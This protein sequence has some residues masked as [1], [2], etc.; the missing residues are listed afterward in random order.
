M[1]II[2][3]QCAPGASLPLVSVYEK[4]RDHTY[5]VVRTYITALWA[6]N[7]LRL[8][9]VSPERAFALQKAHIQMIQRSRR[10]P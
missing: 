7:R 8:C 6:L 9:M 4:V 1:S 10:L 2:T 3:Q 5:S